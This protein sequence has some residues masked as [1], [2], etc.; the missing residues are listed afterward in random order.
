[1]GERGIQLSDGGKGKEA[2]LFDLCKK[3]STM[4]QI[5]IAAFANNS[6]KLWKEKLRTSEGKF[7]V[8][9]IFIARTYHVPFLS[10]LSPHALHHLLFALFTQYKNLFTAVI[11]RKRGD[12]GSHRAYRRATSLS[13]IN[14]VKKKYCDCAARPIQ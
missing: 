6:K 3:A 4:K 7:P 5:K 14:E 9:K 12:P 10:Y 2:E 11:A 13:L 8:Q 1:M